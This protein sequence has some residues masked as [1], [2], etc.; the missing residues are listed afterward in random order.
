MEVITY[1]VTAIYAV[2]FIESKCTAYE[3]AIPM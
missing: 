1:F 3:P 2:C